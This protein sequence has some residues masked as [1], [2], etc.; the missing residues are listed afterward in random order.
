MDIS[1]LLLGLA[2]FAIAY[3]AMIGLV[4]YSAKRGYWQVTSRRAD[5]LQRVGAGFLGAGLLLGMLFEL[6][7]WPRAVL[8]VVGG[9][10]M[11]ASIYVRRLPQ[12][13]KA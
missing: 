10:L 7:K 8:L 5:L 6:P 4:I 11:I 12:E 13:K 2:G 3:T 1:S 9:S